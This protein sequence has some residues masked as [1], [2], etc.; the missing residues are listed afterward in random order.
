M[1]QLG[2]AAVEETLQSGNCQVLAM[3]AVSGRAG[4]GVPASR[5]DVHLLKAYS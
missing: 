4:Y 3:L 1:P 5:L 2:L